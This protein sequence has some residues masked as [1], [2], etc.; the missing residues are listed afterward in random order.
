MPAHFLQIH[1]EKHLNKLVQIQPIRTFPNHHLI[2]D[3]T[4]L[5]DKQ[6]RPSVCLTITKRSLGQK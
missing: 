2:F 3:T 6:S 1:A 4:S 5:A